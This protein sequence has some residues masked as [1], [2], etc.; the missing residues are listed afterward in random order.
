MLVGLEK[1]DYGFYQGGITT[2]NSVCYNDTTKV[3]M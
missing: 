3:V 2:C 1:L